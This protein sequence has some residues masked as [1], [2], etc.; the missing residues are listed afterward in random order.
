M[1]VAGAH[2]K[3]TTSAMTAHA[4]RGAGIDASF[5]IGATVLGVEGAVGGAYLGKSRVAVIEADESDGSFLAYRP[6]VAVITNVEADHLDH[7]GTPE[8]VEAAFR[9]FSE[10]APIL[11]VCADDEAA[12]RVG[13]P[14]A[15]PRQPP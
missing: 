12:A 5:A 9:G 8:A 1:A 14:S 4:L 3:T 10:T 15:L 2:G 13:E 11:V 7:Y 6:A